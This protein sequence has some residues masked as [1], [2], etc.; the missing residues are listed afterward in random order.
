VHDTR[1]KKSRDLRQSIRASLTCDV[2][3]FLCERAAV[4]NP[5][6]RT[7]RSQLCELPLE[8]IDSCEK[9][10]HVEDVLLRHLN[11]FHVLAAAGVSLSI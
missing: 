11:G 5:W 3:E 7:I 6:K 9:D 1:A 8:V 10:F 2:P 4:M